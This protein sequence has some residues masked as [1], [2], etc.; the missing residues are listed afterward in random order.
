[1]ACAMQIDNIFILNFIS[2]NH[3][4]KWINYL[5]EKE[6]KFCFNYKICVHKSQKL[7]YSANG[8]IDTNCNI[9]RWKKF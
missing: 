3:W 5:I 1:M 4:S 8:L 7:C 2:N 9:W 6:I